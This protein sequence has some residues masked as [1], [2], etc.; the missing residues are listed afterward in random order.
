[1]VNDKRFELNEV[2]S[3]LLNP[4]FGNGLEKQFENI[5]A[6]FKKIATAEYLRGRSGTT[7]HCV[8]I[9]LNR[10]DN[11]DTGIWYKNNDE[12][13]QPVSLTSSNIL[14]KLEQVVGQTI[15]PTINEQGNAN[16]PEL[17]LFIE[18]DNQGHKRAVSSMPFIY[19]DPELVDLLNN[20]DYQEQDFQD[21]SGIFLF[22]GDD[23]EKATSYP[24]LYYN[25]EIG[26]FCWIING[27][28]TELIARGPQGAPG[29]NGTCLVVQIGKM[30]EVKTEDG[31]IT[32]PFLYPIKAILF[33]DLE[34]GFTWKNLEDF[35][36]DDPVTNY[37]HNDQ[38]VIAIPNDGA[39][40]E[41]SNGIT[42]SAHT[43]ACISPIVTRVGDMFESDGDTDY[44]CV[45][46][47]YSNTISNVVTNS[48]LKWILRSVNTNSNDLKGLYV[49]NNPT[50]INDIEYAPGSAD[51]EQT[52]FPNGV[53]MMHVDNRNVLNF[54]H[55]TKPE[56]TNKFGGN[57]HI[58]H[59]NFDYNLHATSIGAR[60]YLATSKIHLGGG[61]ETINGDDQGNLSIYYDEGSSETSTIYNR[62]TVRTIDSGKIWMTIKSVAGAEIPLITKFNTRIYNNSKIHMYNKILAYSTSNS[63]CYAIPI[64]DLNYGD[65]DD[66]KGI[67]SPLLLCCY[68]DEMD[69]LDGHEGWKLIE[70]GGSPLPWKICSSISTTSLGQPWYMKVDSISPVSRIYDYDNRTWRDYS[71]D[72]ASLVFKDINFSLVD[73][74]NNICEWICEEDNKVYYSQKPVQEINKNIVLMP[75]EIG[76]HSFNEIVGYV[77]S[78][79]TL[80]LSRKFVCEFEDE[81]Y[82]Y[83]WLSNSRIYINDNTYSS[84]ANIYLEE[85]KGLM[86]YSIESIYP[87]RGKISTRFGTIDNY[88]QNYYIN[89]QNIL[90]TIDDIKEKLNTLSSAAAAISY[91]NEPAYDEEVYTE[92][93]YNGEAYNG[94]ETVNLDEIQNTILTIQNQ[95]DSISN[96]IPL[97][98]AESMENDEAVQNAISNRILYTMRNNASVSK[99]IDSKVSTSL[100]DTNSTTYKTMKQQVSNVISTDS[101]VSDSLSNVVVNSIQTNTNVQN[102]I[103]VQTK[104]ALNE[105]SSKSIIKDVVNNAILNDDTTQLNIENYISD[106]LVTES[107]LNNNITQAVM[108]VANTQAFKNALITSLKDVMVTKEEF[109]QYINAEVNITEGDSNLS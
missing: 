33:P 3:P 17:I 29:Q 93:A 101:N 8:T 84:Q 96:Q 86:N 30:I 79:E 34:K 78:G 43:W 21:N 103:K 64:D 28:E 46:A 31:Q 100:N 95:L 6:N 97:M 91:N 47:D 61:E 90:K 72:G 48:N 89:G 36:D 107:Q 66:N 32:T 16:Y 85:W 11:S 14:N 87:Y 9:K 77:K 59:V 53:H 45:Y 94:E 26:E 75:K 56:S 5:D 22:N 50:S 7:T 106:L 60:D 70:N 76:E 81:M 105:D 4:D 57:D 109:N 2:R 37:L 24:T 88:C 80:T 52:Y 68:N 74:K 44:F 63:A 99:A 54:K 73:I 40:I 65:Y 92:P 108:K 51:Y 39:E 104:S 19:H 18:D 23:F 27:T 1:M 58:S 49:S 15:E 10:D 20:K 38:I 102:Q 62:I 83:N 98:I 71:F 25:K 42:Y 12:A 69:Y 41:L 35:T 67:T 82:K 13:G 55:T